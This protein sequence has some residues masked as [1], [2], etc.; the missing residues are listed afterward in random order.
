MKN[1]FRATTQISSVSSSINVAQKD[2]KL[3]RFSEANIFNFLN[4]PKD[5]DTKIVFV[6]GNF[7]ILHPGHFRLLRFAKSRGDFLIVGVM[8]DQSSGVSEDLGDRVN[9]VNALEFVD[10]VIQ[11][12]SPLL[13]LIKA[14]KPDFVVKG[15]EHEANES[16]DEKNVIEA[17]GGRLIYSSGVAGDMGIIRRNKEIG[18]LENWATFAKHYADRHDISKDKLEK[19]ISK[20]SELKVSVLGDIIV[21]EYIN[22]TPIGMSQED[23]SIVVKPNSKT[24]F[25]GGAAIVAAHAAGLGASTQFF[26]VVGSDP[27][28]DF[29]SKNLEDYKINSH[30]IV[31][32]TRQSTLKQKFRGNGKSLFKVN[33]YDDHDITGSVCE[34]L[35]SLIMKKIE[36]SDLLVLSDF[37]YGCVPNKI[38]DPLI[39]FCRNNDTTV[40]ADS[41]SSSQLGDICRFQNI[42]LITPTEHEARISLQDAKSGI[43]LIADKLIQ[44]TNV[45]NV[46]ITLGPDGVL[47]KPKQG[48]GELSY[49]MLPSFNA[50]PI[51]VSGAGDCLLISTSM[52]KCVGATI[53]E[54]ALI[55]SIAAGIQVAKLGNSPIKIEEVLSK[56]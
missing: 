27:V 43:T 33:H 41:Q 56:I 7:N 47:I 44:K 16:L 3:S 5:K 48:S 25:L 45:E 2:I 19:I 22:C 30:I 4:L 52:A 29:I 36:Q 38:V 34:E 55:G 28:G 53:W 6:Y 1:F 40:V 32:K 50:A 46:I 35:L 39:G 17:N 24:R 20:M 49:D 9:N 21:D 23:P 10:R 15:K 37:N 13:D 18:S 14:L 51:D 8:P 11:V 26:S 54:S 12:T 31:D 42:H